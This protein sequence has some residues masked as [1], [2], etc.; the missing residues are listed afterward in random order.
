MLHYLLP[1]EGAAEAAVTGAASQAAG[2][3]DV[4][5]V[6][7]TR[8]L[9][10]LV[11]QETHQGVDARTVHVVLVVQTTGEDSSCHLQTE[12]VS[13]SHDVRGHG[14]TTLNNKASACHGVE[15]Q[16]KCSSDYKTVT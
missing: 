15:L 6:Q 13:V 1:T 3:E 8:G 9:V 11:T 5:A 2:A 14:I 12:F 7:Q 4:V 16:S 10:L